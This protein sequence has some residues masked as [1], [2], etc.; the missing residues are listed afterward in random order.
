MALPDWVSGSRRQ[1]PHPGALALGCAR[2]I[3]NNAGKTLNDA[4]CPS[5]I[6]RMMFGPMFVVNMLWC[7]AASGAGRLVEGVGF[8]PT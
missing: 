5:L 8:E 3:G 4:V 1:N 2:L 6:Y 7:N